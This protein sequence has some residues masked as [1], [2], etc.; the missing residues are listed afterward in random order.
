MAG[1]HKV[2]QHTTPKTLLRGFVDT[3][4]RLAMRRRDETDTL[5]SVNK[6]SVRSNFYSYTADGALVDD[7]EDW[8]NSAIETPVTPV[9]IRARQGGILTPADDAILA[10]FA[11]CGLLRTATTRSYLQQIGDHL[12]PVLV[13]HQHLVRRN[14]DPSTLSSAEWSSVEA[15]AEAEW[16][17]LGKPADAD[18]ADL[19]VFLREFDQLS[20]RLEDWTWSVL[21]AAQACLITD[22]A[23]VAVLPSADDGWQGILPA[24]SPVFIPVSSSRLIIGEPHPIAG[25]DRLNLRLARAVNARLALEAYDAVFADP[26]SPWPVVPALAPARPTLPA[27][28]VTWSRS[29]G[30]DS[31]YPAVYPEVQDDAVRRLLDSLG[32]TEVVA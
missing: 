14:I 7:V 29:S 19:R 10:R 18:H 3:R 21:T 28:R 32:A 16:R 23:P 31:T 26:R 8:L 1:Q 30:E 5:I 11:A 4:S 12:G 25:T 2:K 24:G 27:P 13:L 17:R 22:D 9:L 15:A 20:A 6:A